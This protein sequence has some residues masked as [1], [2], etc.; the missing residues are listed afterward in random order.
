MSLPR[1]ASIFD[2][3]PQKVARFHAPLSD[4]PLDVT[5]CSDAAFDAW[6]GDQFP[7]LDAPHPAFEHKRFND[8]MLHTWMKLTTAATK[9]QVKYTQDLW[10]KNKT[11]RPIYEDFMPKFS[12]GMDESDPYMYG[13]GGIT[14]EGLNQLQDAW[15]AEQNRIEAMR[16]KPLTLVARAEMVQT[17]ISLVV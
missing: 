8:D 9:A 15:L 10:D 4:A 5:E 13:H 7:S 1:P 11:R 16:Q 17:K 3:P 2:A 12:S 6:L 14:D